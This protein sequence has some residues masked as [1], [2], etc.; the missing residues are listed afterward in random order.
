MTRPLLLQAL[1]QVLLATTL[2]GLA[3]GLLVLPQRRLQRP[4]EQGVIS[5]HLAADGA[6]RL[7]NQPV[8]PAELQRL[9]ATPALRRR[10]LRLRVVPD[11]GTPWGDVHRLLRQL[12]PLPQSLELQLPATPPA[13]G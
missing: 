2:C 13:A 6:L 3:F 11:P 4:L 5:L 10:A 12:D 8:A 1:G 7:W 9:L